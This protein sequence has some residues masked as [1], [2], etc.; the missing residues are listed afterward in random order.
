MVTTNVVAAGDK[1]LVRVPVTVNSTAQN[2]STISVTLGNTTTVGAQNV[3]YTSN[4]ATPANQVY[5]VDGASGDSGEI[6]GN[7]ANGEREASATLSATVGVQVEV[8]N[9]PD[10]APNAVGLGNSEEA[11]FT[12]QSTAVPANLDPT[13]VFDPDPRSF[14]NTIQNPSSTDTVTLSLLPSAPP[15]LTDLPDATQVT[16]SFNS[17]SAIYQYNQTTGKYSFVSGTGTVN[18]QALSKTNPIE[19]TLAAGAEQDYQVSIDLPNN[20]A[21]LEGFP[22]AITAFYDA[23]NDGSITFTDIAG[24]KTGIYDPGEEMQPANTT[25]N[26]LHTGFLK[27]VKES[28]ILQGTGPKVRLG[29]EDFSEDGKSPAPGNIIVYHITYTNVTEADPVANSGSKTLD[30]NVVEISEDGT[31][32]PSNWATDIDGDGNNDTSHFIG[33]TD[34]SSGTVQYYSGNS[35]ATPLTGE[36]SGTTADTDVTKYV[37]I[38]STSIPPQGNGTFTIQRKVNKESGSRHL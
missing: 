27:L 9:G 13:D 25:T 6:T 1:I 20:T 30:A 26:R 5:T 28:Q 31:Q 17:L 2:N 33:A 36:Q 19:I 21:Q 18:G 16:I 38:L 11:D 15:D 22:V 8:L 3:D 12:N 4:G 34:R 29:D 14:T 37:D 35:G 10:G 24:G 32:A 7:P 23:N